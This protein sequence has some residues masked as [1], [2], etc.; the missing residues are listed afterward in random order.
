MGHGLP[1]SPL[2]RFVGPGKLMRALKVTSKKI[3]QQ[4]AS[5]AATARRVL[6]VES[7]SVRDLSARIDDTFVSVV[8]LL[9]ECR[10]HVVVTGLG[11]S[12]IIGTKI[13]ATFSSI[14]LPAVFMHA[15]EASHG[16]MGILRENNLVIA[17]SNSGETQEVLCLVPTISKRKC[18]LVALTGNASSTLAKRADFVLDVSVKEEAC[19]KGLVPTASTTAALAM[20]DALA[21]SLLDL[22]G[23]HEEDFAENH[24]GGS[25][26][27]RLLTTV[28]DLMHSGDRV[29]QVPLDAACMAVLKEMS[30]KRL[31]ATLVV[32]AKHR[33]KGIITDGDI[34]RMMEKL[35]DIRRIKA[36]EMMH[37]NPKSV[38]QGSLASD[39]V[40]LMEQFKITSLAVT[41]DGK[42]IDGILHLHDLLRAGI[43]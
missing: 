21:M 26:G 20:G 9:D 38:P 37:A 29:P 12:G 14:G 43:V 6:E 35:G 25:L 36:R 11:K 1:V 32:D 40:R 39:A 4:N 17:I 8:R 18:T 30:E 3:T 15:T 27:R 16:D 2:P 7:R 13:A 19:L 41:E 42:K 10:G 28:A 31:G 34:R 24:P 22:R 23:F 5:L 33:L